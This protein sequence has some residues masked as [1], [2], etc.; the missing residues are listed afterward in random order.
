MSFF[1]YCSRG[2]NVKATEPRI[3]A[4]SLESLQ[5]PAIR[6]LEQ[7]QVNH[8]DKP[9][10]STPQQPEV[11]R[12]SFSESWDPLR[13]YLREAIVYPLLSR[14]EE[15]AVAR[16]VRQGD[17]EARERMI[18]SNLRLVVKIAKDYEG[19]GLSNLDAI[20]LGNIG[21][22]RAVDRFDPE[23]GAK[24]STYAVWWIRQGIMRGLTNLSR[25]IRIPAHKV[26]QIARLKKTVNDLESSLGREVSFDEIAEEAGLPTREV[27]R[28]LSISSAT[29]SLDAPISEHQDENVASTIADDEQKTPSFISAHQ[30]LLRLAHRYLGKLAAR[31]HTILSRRFGL[32]GRSPETLEDIGQDYGLTRERIRQ[33]EAKALVK[34]RRMIEQDGK[35]KESLTR[36]LS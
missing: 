29:V 31:E 8:K 17:L 4:P 18:L 21:L 25:T 12:V 28:L 2:D 14:E 30:D 19:Y 32:N 24:F 5:V 3:E 6:L 16:Q 15:I 10:V 23:V 7:K 33:I 26:Q 34:L 1:V 13:V 9:G 11:S 20:N 22:M 27:R 35:G 36:E